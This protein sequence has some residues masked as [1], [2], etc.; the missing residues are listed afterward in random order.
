ME[1]KGACKASTLHTES[2]RQPLTCVDSDSELMKIQ[3][4][5]LL[6]QTDNGYE[7]STTLVSF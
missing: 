4:M 6:V 3:L 2:R 5:L 1:K 7:L